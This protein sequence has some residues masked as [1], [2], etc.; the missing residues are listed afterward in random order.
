MYTSTN[1]KSKK[2]V[3]DAIKN[4]DIIT[5]FQPGGMFDGETQNGSCTLE[6]PHS[7]K[8]HRWYG[9]GVLKDGQLISIK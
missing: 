9:Q 2:A 4:G 8:P 7:P 6:G 1:Y 3:K 5:V